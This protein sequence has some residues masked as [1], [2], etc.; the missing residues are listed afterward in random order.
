[1]ETMPR[2]FKTAAVG[3]TFDEFHKG[4]RTLLMRA[5]EIADCVLIGLSSDSFVKRMGKKHKTETYSRRLSDLTDFLRERGLFERAEI[6]SLNDPYGVMLTS[7]QVEALVVSKETEKIALEIQ[8]KR[9]EAGL[10]LQIVTIEMV[11]SD[12]HVPI[13]TTRIRQGRIDREGHL[14][15]TC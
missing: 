13:S 15:R 9:K 5:F 3:G 11:P 2:H 10:P 4:H 8:S 1:M 7:K 12:N 14:L 6:V